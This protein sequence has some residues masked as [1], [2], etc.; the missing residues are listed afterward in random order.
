MRID[1]FELIEH[2]CHESE[3]VILT[4][5][6]YFS[7]SVLERLA[8]AVSARTASAARGRPGGCTCRSR[9]MARTRRCTRQCGGAHLRSH[10]RRHPELVAL[11]A[12]PSGEHVSDHPNVNRMAETMRLLA[13][14]GVKEHHLLWLQER[15]RA[16]DNADDLLLIPSRVTAV[17]RELS[18]LA[19]EL[20]MV[21]D[22]QTSHRVRVRGKRGRKTDLCNCGYESLDVFSDGQVYPCVWFSGAPNLA[23]GSIL[24]RSLKEIWLTSPTL[25]A[26]HEPQC[27][28]GRGAASATSN[29]CVAAG[30]IARRTSTALPGPAAAAS[31]LRA[32]LRDVDGP[33]LRPALRAGGPRGR[34]GLTGG[35]GRL[36][37]DGR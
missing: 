34:A 29:T 5:T 28:G 33:H 18:A 14:L 20:G 9:L 17:M 1:I 24:E 6:T 30:R 2:V 36:R 23:C 8:G 13:S 16:V 7:R 11:G 4:N 35:A 10:D 25:A 37:G 21:I 26:I 19:S 12:H 15:G 31:R 3:L 22:N 27:S 32:V